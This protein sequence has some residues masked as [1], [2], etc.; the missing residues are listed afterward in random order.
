MGYREQFATAGAPEKSNRTQSR[1]TMHRLVLRA[2]P[3]DFWVDRD[4]SKARQENAL[5]R[6]HSELPIYR[7]DIPTCL[8]LPVLPPALMGC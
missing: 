1:P 3:L 4:A 2:Y 7:T 6:L 5:Q 8:K